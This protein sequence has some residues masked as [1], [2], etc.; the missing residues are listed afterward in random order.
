REAVLRL[1]KKGYGGEVYKTDPMN[2]AGRGIWQVTLKGNLDG[3][4]YTYQIRDASGWLAETPGIYAAAVG[5]NGQRAM[6]LDMQ[7]TN[8]SGWAEDKGPRIG[9]PN[10]AIIYEL[11]IRDMTIHP[12]SGSSYPGKYLGLA[13]T[14][15]RGTG[16]QPT[17]LDHLR[18]L[19][20]THIHLLPAFDYRSVDET[21]LDE[22][23]FNWGYD[24]VNY[25]VP[26]GSY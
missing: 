20:I 23:Q 22:P 4:F 16:A 5:V 2:P 24:P 14:G 10:D 19:G 15:T 25:N 6:V 21:R 13:E 11:H 12:N 18:E 7:R 3:V 1:Y 9:K 26:E 8:P 17:G